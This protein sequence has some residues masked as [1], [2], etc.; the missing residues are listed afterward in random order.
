[1]KK[2]MIVKS[3]KGRSCDHA[4]VGTHMFT[5]ALTDINVAYTGMQNLN[6][7]Y[8]CGCKCEVKEVEA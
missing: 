5:C 8:T 6:K 7:T 2:Y 1:M 4:L 3:V